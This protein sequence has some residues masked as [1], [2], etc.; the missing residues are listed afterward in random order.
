MRFVWDEIK[1][2]VN[3]RKHGVSF[4]LA[5][6]LFDSPTTEVEDT[7]RDYGER[8][9]I[10]YGVIETRVYCCVYTDRGDTRRV[11]SLRKANKDESDDYFD[12]IGA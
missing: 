6:E 9:V 5:N 1:N 7:R 11:I 12:A 4:S 8:R 2:A 10:C 3:L